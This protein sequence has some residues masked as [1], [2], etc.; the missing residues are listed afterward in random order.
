MRFLNHKQ[1]IEVI[2]AAKA[3]KEVLYKNQMLC[4]YDLAT[5]VHKQWIWYDSVRQLL[6][7]LGLRHGITP[8]TK[9]VI[10]YREQT[11]AFNTMFALHKAAYTIKLL[12]SRRLSLIVFD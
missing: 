8:P 11:C 3:K 7:S 10:I 6:W 2:K 5:E 1:K 12:K 4:F 9:L